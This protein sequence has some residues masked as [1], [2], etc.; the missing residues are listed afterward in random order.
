MDKIQKLELALRKLKNY[1]IYAK[2][3]R[4]R[5]FSRGRGWRRA[6]R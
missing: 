1:K 2:F 5:T 6:K 4:K 3:G